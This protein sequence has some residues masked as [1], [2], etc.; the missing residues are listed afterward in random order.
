MD[1]PGSSRFLG[2]SRLLRRWQELCGGFGLDI[3]DPERAL[4][5][6][7][8]PPRPYPGLRS[9]APDDTG[10]FFARDR[11][12]DGLV[13]RLSRANI[14]VVLGGSG[15]GKSSLVRAGLIPRLFAGDAVPGRPG[16]WYVLELRPGEDPNAALLAAIAGQLLTPILEAPDPDAAPGEPTFGQRALAQAFGVEP[17][18]GT[19]A[20]RERLL[21]KIAEEL[22]PGSGGGGR[23]LRSLWLNVS[24]LFTL[25]GEALDRLDEVLS[26]G[27]RAGAP[28]LLILVD[29][30]EEV[31]RPE[32]TREGRDN[33]RRLVEATFEERPSCLFLA[34]TLRSE[35]LHRCAEGGLAGIIT[36]TAYL[37][38]PLD[39]DTERRDIIVSPARA[40]I[41]DWAGVPDDD[42]GDRDA[43]PF[44]AEVVDLLLREVRHLLDALTH[45]SDHLPLLQHG[46]LQIWDSAAERWRRTLAEGGVPDLRI[47]RGDVETAMRSDLSTPGWLV[48]CLNRH[49]DAVYAMAVAEAAQRMPATGTGETREARAELVLRTLFCAMAR[50]DDRGNW[51]RRFVTARRAAA[52]LDGPEAAA[53]D[54]TAAMAAVLTVFQAAGYLNVGR[55]GDEPIYDVSHEALIRNWVRYS[56]GLR[57]ADRIGEALAEVVGN[58]ET[59]PPP[60][61]RPGILRWVPGWVVRGRNWVMEA[62]EKRAA[63]AVPDRFKENVAKVLGPTPSVSRPLAASLLADRAE[64]TSPAMDG[65]T[66]SPEGRKALEHRM[67]DSIAA[68][69]APFALATRYAGR[70]VSRLLYFVSLLGGFTLLFMG[71]LIVVGIDWF[72][73]TQTNRELGIANK[74]LHMNAVAAAVRYREAGPDQESPE[75]RA[76]ELQQAHRQIGTLDP[77]ALGRS[78]RE[79]YLAIGS[80]E[81]AA[82]SLTGAVAIRV[83]PAVPATPRS[84][85][86]LVLASGERDRPASPPILQQVGSWQLGASFRQAPDVRR[87][88]WRPVSGS[89]ALADRATLA[90]RGVSLEVA[91]KGEIEIQPYADTLFCLSPDAQLLMAW[92]RER[93]PQFYAIEWHCVRPPDGSSPAAGH[94][95][96]WDAA[97][98]PLSA[99]LASSD[100]A[101]GN[102]VQARL[103]S[104]WL[105]VAID[106]NTRS[107][108]EA[109]ADYAGPDGSGTLRRGF[110]FGGAADRVVADLS[111]GMLRPFLSADANPQ[112]GQAACG[113]PEGPDGCGDDITLGGAL[114]TVH[115]WEALPAPPAAGAPTGCGLSACRVY[116][117]VRR[118]I[119]PGTASPRVRIAGLSFWTGG[120]I[121]RIAATD[122]TLEFED[123]YGVW[124][125]V[126]VDLEAQHERVRTLAPATI[127]GLEHLSDACRAIYCTEWTKEEAK[128]D[129]KP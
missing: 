70:R 4:E 120:P 80:W 61:V 46:L 7:L 12:I 92:P 9:F 117:D 84:S 97:V 22:F 44:T 85:C 103:R 60:S 39:D 49:A 129:G 124:R 35:E 27:L 29:Q 75:F 55:K 3:R 94:C 32:V 62:A 91:Q 48:R 126:V 99:R 13:E 74:A 69:E 14:M 128:A 41:N 40:V 54:T 111:P 125:T 42:P 113:V 101:A 2:A 112:R 96:A 31:F 127:P 123:A 30:F 104:A 56:D 1:D 38:G 33:L 121:R 86:S 34:L 119:V 100:V 53:G 76:F 88:F 19:D 107:P 25:A 20:L 122:T 116:I 89:L 18:G 68:V 67:L 64:R 109:I 24:A 37:L 93:L 57:E 83:L 43:V 47:Q 95:A 15:C 66:K 110:S 106:G 45:S 16:R 105:A 51:A 115:R 21:R 26:R 52:L 114:V 77:D 63:E 23:D 73:V 10:L 108:K 6:G 36:D 72:T 17:A 90:T 71:G 58:V 78:Q 81:Q 79:L 98:S 59:G 50:R 82:R 11:Q 65:A 28:N 8:T 102:D 5:V 118:Q 87:I